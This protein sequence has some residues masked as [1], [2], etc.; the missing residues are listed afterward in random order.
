LLLAGGK[1]PTSGY[2]LTLTDTSATVIKE[3]HL[4]V[5]ESELPEEYRSFHWFWELYSGE[6]ALYSDSHDP[7]SPSSPTGQEPIVTALLRYRGSDESHVYV[8]TMRISNLPALL[9]KQPVR[10]Q[11]H[12]QWRDWKEYTHILEGTFPRGSTSFVVSGCKIVWPMK[13]EGDIYPESIRITVFKP[14]LADSDS[15]STIVKGGVK[16]GLQSIDCE[17]DVP[18]AFRM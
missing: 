3:N 5:K 13:L 10:R 8:I 17:K 2:A 11:E 6:P 14:Q 4:K 15:D 9:E 1:S 12:V 7:H 16:S 18:P